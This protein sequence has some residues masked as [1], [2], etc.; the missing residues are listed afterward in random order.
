MKTLATLVMV[1]GMVAT[2]LAQDEVATDLVA[3]Q[4]RFAPVIVQ[5]CHGR[6]D[7]ITRFDFDGNWNGDDNWENFEK[8]S[9]LPASVYTSAIESTTHVF[10]SY[11]LF[12]PRDWLPV[13]LPLVS[14]EN[15]FEGVLVVVE[16]PA[17]RVTHVETFAHYFLH[18][19]APDRNE[20]GGQT[21][22]LVRFEGEHPIVRVEAYKHGVYAYQD[23]S[24]ANAAGVIYRYTGTASEPRDKNDKNCGYDFVS[25]E[26]SF[27]ARRNEVGRDKIYAKTATFAM[28]TFGTNFNGTSYANDRAA[29]PW[30]WAD[31]RDR[32][33]AQGDWFFDPALA[34]QVHF[35]ARKAAFSREYLVNPYLHGGATARDVT[36]S[37]RFEQLASLD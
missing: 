14:H 25:I 33:L 23:A 1:L 28:G 27:W 34:M 32:G 19:Y 18:R 4:K 9:R 13:S 5:N 11:Y 3:L 29:A 7:Y 36:R 6:A 21:D 8:A 35:P 26:S 22:G 15:D 17:M 20:A 24:L 31:K 10:L 30:S 37:Q 16:K 2:A 12:H